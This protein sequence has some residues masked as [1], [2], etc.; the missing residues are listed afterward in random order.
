MDTHST[1]PYN[2]IIE[3]LR[4]IG[5][6]GS[7]LEENY[8]FGDW[9]SPDLEKREIAAAAFGQT[10]VAY[11]SALIGIACAN[12][13]REQALVNQY[14][15]LGAPVILEIDTHEIREWSVSVNR[16]A[17][18]LIDRY[19]IGQI[20][21]LLTNRASEWKPESFLRAKNIGDF[22]W[23]R[24][25]ELFSGLVPEL[26]EQIRDKL[27][28]L[29]RETLSATKQAYREET[30]RAPDE[31]KLFKVVFWLLTAKVFRDRRV[32]A[33]ASL[34][35]APSADQL[36]EAVAKHYRSEVP[37]VLTKNARQVAA[38]HIWADLDFRN[39]SVEV[40]SHIWS[41]TLIDPHT[42]RRLG[43]H[44]TS[45][46][47]VRYI[48][49][50]I[51]FEASGDDELIILEPCAGS[52]VF[53]IGVMNVLRQKWFG[54]APEAR[55]E[56][57]T[58]HLAAIERDPFGVEIST[59]ALTLADFPNPNGWNVRHDDVFRPGALEDQL[60]CAGMVF[61]ALSRNL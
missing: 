16:D 18:R 44:R 22:R 46:S 8:G 37:S 35:N 38:S 27:D 14:R 31:S 57:F 41:T 45:R 49:E 17:H 20:R 15:A 30:G 55:H 53:L 11:D 6:S 5:Y 34:G 54:V 4:S 43:I 25:L 33:F 59:L 39:L 40:L 26:E 56:Y 3:G 7:L 12:G 51:P 2:Q 24:Q 47:I 10:P 9:F 36:L 52:A 42:T 61:W 1:S 28:P 48:V 13:V 58:N 60:K 29:L 23:S 32:P 19:P 50:K 21:Q